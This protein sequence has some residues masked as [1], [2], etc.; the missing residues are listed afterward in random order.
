MTSSVRS[1]A[2]RAAASRNAESAPR[3]RYQPPV[4][5]P[6]RARSLV[7]GAW[8]ALSPSGRPLAAL[9]QLLGRRFG[10]AS[11]ILC[12]SGTGALQLALDRCR[13][14]D[15]R[16]RVALPAYACFDVVT[17]AVGVD[18][19]L[20]FYD[21]DPATLSP[22]EASLVGVLERGVDALVVVH[23][24]GVPVDWPRI[25]EHAA[26]FG[27]QLVE[28]AAQG[29]GAS[30]GEQP[31]GSLA[32]RSVLS[33]GRGKGWTGGRGGALLLR[34]SADD[35]P[36]QTSSE[37]GALGLAAALWALGRPPLYRIPAS[38]PALGL[39]ETRYREPHPGA[40]MARAAAAAIIDSD[41]S[42]SAEARR[43]MQNA[44]WLTAALSASSDVH[45]IQ[46]P[47]RGM[48]GYLRLPVLLAGGL[49]AAASS[50]VARRLGIAPAYPAVLP[51][52]PASRSRLVP[53]SAGPYPGAERLVRELFT[54]PTHSLLSE[55]ERQ[56]LVDFLLL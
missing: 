27:A 6:L 11:V 54:L 14:R 32:P 2:A 26:R 39:G 41:S 3:G 8:A 10:A 16:L 51:V 18:A 56:T 1:H 30:F 31:L 37:L 43:R 13:R 47:A 55:A 25:A 17:A 21:L 15:G 38:I 52:L 45:L 9:R 4:Y 46:P 44:V 36:E 20:S 40:R 28:D 19:E 7:I 23:L 42:A 29:H 33:F 53:G 5:S 34:D 48:P 35:E 49:R 50:D 22:D 24:Y 12:E